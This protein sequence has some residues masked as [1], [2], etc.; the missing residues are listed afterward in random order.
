MQPRSSQESKTS[1]GPLGFTLEQLMLPIDQGSFGTDTFLNQ[2]VYRVSDQASADKFI[3]ELRFWKEHDRH[4]F[5]IAMNLR[6]TDGGNLLHAIVISENFYLLRQFMIN[7]PEM[8]QTYNQ[9]KAKNSELIRK[10]G[11]SSEGFSPVDYLAA[12][13]R[14]LRK[15]IVEFQGLLQLVSCSIS[16]EL[17]KG[18]IKWLEERVTKLETAMSWFSDQARATVSSSTA[19]SSSASAASQPSVVSGQPVVIN[20]SSTTK[21]AEPLAAAT[22]LASLSIAVSFSSASGSAAQQPGGSKRPSSSRR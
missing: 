10:Y 4:N 5:D 13:V 19:A 22:A 21:A 1:T 11:M 12:V 8:A 17:M 3:A 2:Q 7:F 6:H 14:E 15:S 16:K 18:N 9:Q 20:P